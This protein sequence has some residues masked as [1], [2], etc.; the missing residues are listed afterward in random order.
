MD[1]NAIA[2]V[3]EQASEPRKSTPHSKTAR[4]ITRR[5]TSFAI[6]FP[7]YTAIAGDRAV[8]GRISNAEDGILVSVTLRSPRRYVGKSCIEE[9]IWEG[10]IPRRPRAKRDETE[11]PAWKP[12]LPFDCGSAALDFFAANKNI[13]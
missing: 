9:K 2:R 6:P 5:F 4:S 13:S 3:S 11:R 1:E 12:A 8:S 7:I 10:R